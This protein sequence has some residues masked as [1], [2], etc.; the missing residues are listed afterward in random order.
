MLCSP[1]HRRLSLAARALLVELQLRWAPD[2]TE[3]WLSSEKAGDALGMS[4]ATGARALKELIE[5]G[6]IVITGE[7][8]FS[9]N[10][11]GKTRAYSLTWESMG[12]REPTGEWQ[13][14]EISRSHP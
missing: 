4:K 1:A 12:G 10:G 9:S 13:T 6:F 5:T 8:Q 2:R 7:S 11:N 3:I 14:A